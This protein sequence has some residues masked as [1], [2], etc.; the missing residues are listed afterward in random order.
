MSA[1]GRSTSPRPLDNQK[2]DDGDVD[3]DSPDKPNAKVVHVTNLTHNVVEAHLRTIFSFYGEIVKLD[4]PT[5]TKCMCKQNFTYHIFLTYS[6]AK[7]MTTCSW[8][9]QRQSIS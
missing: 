4:L 5:F 8:P 2:G 9:K 6:N 7:T 1:R 3:M